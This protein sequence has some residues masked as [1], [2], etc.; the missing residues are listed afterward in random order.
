MQRPLYLRRS[1]NDVVGAMQRG[2]APVTVAQT[3]AV[4]QTFKD[5]PRSHWAYDAV[6]AICAKHLSTTYPQ[7]AMTM[8]SELI[9]LFHVGSSTHQLSLSATH[10]S[11]SLASFRQQH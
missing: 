7:P 11:V 3:E 9:E 4:T 6:I 10:M 2:W 8:V 1:P 5:V